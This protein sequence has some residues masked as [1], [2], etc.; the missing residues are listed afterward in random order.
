MTTSA[1]TREQASSALIASRLKLPSAPVTSDASGPSKVPSRSTYKQRIAAAPEA[2]TGQPAA[3]QGPPYSIAGNGRDQRD[4][5]LGGATPNRRGG[6]ASRPRR[7]LRI[8]ARAH[9]CYPA[10]AE[11]E[12]RRGPPAGRD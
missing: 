8:E 11:L 9:R 5:A 2:A 10:T 12:G 7:H 1:P 3:P 4:R 6:R